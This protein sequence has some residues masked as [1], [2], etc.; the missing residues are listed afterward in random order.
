MI[1]GIKMT[2]LFLAFSFCGEAV[3]FS[4]SGETYK[5]DTIPGAILISTF[6]DIIRGKLYG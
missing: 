2:K 3:C 1:M 4:I 5:S 6:S